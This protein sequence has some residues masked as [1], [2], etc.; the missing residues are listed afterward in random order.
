MDKSLWQECRMTW[1][2]KLKFTP[3]SQ[4]TGYRKVGSM[5]ADRF[6]HSKHIE[7]TVSQLVWTW[8][9]TGRLAGT[10]DCTVRSQHVNNGVDECLTCI[11]QWR[12]QWFVDSC[13]TQR[14]QSTTINNSINKLPYTTCI[15][16][17]ISMTLLVGRQAKNPVACKTYVYPVHKKLASTPLIIK[18]STGQPRFHR[19][20]GQ[21]F[22]RGLSYFC[23]KNFS[24]A[25]E[26][27]F[28]QRPKN[29]Y[30]KLQNYFAWFTPPS[31]Y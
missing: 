31:N 9:L 28:R 12:R 5:K 19:H 8:Q 20:M 18:G 3:A 26:K 13:N 7:G 14:Q 25:P 22:L 30:A 17:G 16:I 6:Q 4:A 2:C 21:F 11:T 29:R 27:F 23:P 10:L 15:Y 1:T 24:T